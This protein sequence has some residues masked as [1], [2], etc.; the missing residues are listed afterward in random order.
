MTEHPGVRSAIAHLGE[1]LQGEVFRG[2]RGD[3]V[4]S[5]RLEVETPPALGDMQQAVELRVRADAPPESRGSGFLRLAGWRGGWQSGESGRWEADI[6]DGPTSS[7][8]LVGRVLAIVR[9][10]RRSGSNWTFRWRA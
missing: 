8:Y 3:L 4:A 7:P 6:F 9:V 1:A 5:Y 2:A 10:R